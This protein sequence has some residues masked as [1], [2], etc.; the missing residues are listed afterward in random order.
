MALSTGLKFKTSTPINVIEDWLDAN[1]K[2]EWDV[3]IE[4]ISTELR[5]KSIAVYFEKEADRDAFKAAY[6]SFT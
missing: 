5:Q 2:G 6:K 1:C 3:D 4:A